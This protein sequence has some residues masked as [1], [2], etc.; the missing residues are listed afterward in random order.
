MKEIQEK[1]KLFCKKNNMESPA[2]HRVLD[3]MSEL[4]EV[5][6]EILK[7]SNYGR[8]PIEYRKE[9]KSELGDVMYS[10]ITVANTFDIDLSDSL[11]QTLK[12]YEK[13]LLKG[14]AGSEKDS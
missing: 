4:G 10:L 7:M 11:E 2:E 5:A 8:K 1:I 14:S 12:K 13:R 3:A 6:K 9:L